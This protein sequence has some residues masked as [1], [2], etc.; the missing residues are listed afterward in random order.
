MCMLCT[1]A[2]NASDLRDEE[3]AHQQEIFKLFKS[4]TFEEIVAKSEANVSTS[5]SVCAY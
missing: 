2:E 5:L 4:G 3:R 1:C